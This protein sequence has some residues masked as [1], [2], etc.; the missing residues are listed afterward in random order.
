[1]LLTIALLFISMKTKLVLGLGAMIILTGMM[2]NAASIKGNPQS[3]RVEGIN[4]AIAGSK[5]P[6]EK[7]TSSFG[8]ENCTFSTT[9]SNPVLHFRARLPACV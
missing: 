1:M 6:D 9:G 2:L 8:L 7:Y 3:L 4:F 5:T